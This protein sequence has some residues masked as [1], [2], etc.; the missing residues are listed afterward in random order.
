M[1]SQAARNGNEI[2]RVRDSVI[3][4][5]YLKKDAYTVDLNTPGN[6]P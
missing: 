3:E 4:I 1:L 5:L 6:E 2:T